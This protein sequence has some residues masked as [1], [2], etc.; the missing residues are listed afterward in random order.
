MLKRLLNQYIDKLQATFPVNRIVVLLT[1]IVFIPASAAVTGWVALHFPG[2]VIPEGLVVGLSG[3]AALGALT[4]AYKWL[5]QW[6]HGENIATQADLE[7]ALGEFTDS[8]DV[9]DLFSA[10]GSLE[11]IGAA[12][13]DLRVRLDSPGDQIPDDQISGELAPIIDT[14]GAVLHDH[15]T[16]RPPAVNAAVAPE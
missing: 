14:I 7:A 4:L 3:A 15:A 13:S 12:L 10:L 2:L 16:K 9:E 11:G 5:D 8:P 1:P 6:Q